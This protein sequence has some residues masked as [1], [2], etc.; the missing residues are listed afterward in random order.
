MSVNLTKCQIW[1]EWPLLT[2]KV[3]KNK[4]ILNIE[5]ILKVKI[6]LYTI[7]EIDVEC[8]SKIQHDSHVS[9]DMLEKWDSNTRGCRC[10]WI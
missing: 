5:P 1:E 8:S 3:E 6:K 9:S 4:I 7:E 2:F 10:S